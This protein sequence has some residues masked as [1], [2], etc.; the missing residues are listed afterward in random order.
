MQVVDFQVDELLMTTYVNIAKH[1]QG[2][3]VA[4]LEAIEDRRVS[5]VGRVH[6]FALVVLLG[7]KAMVVG[8][9]F[10]GAHTVKDQVGHG[11]EQ[12]SNGRENGQVL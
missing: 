7:T 1:V 6:T 4:A 9:L 8:W 12:N 10:K 3:L 5:C 11:R 2:A